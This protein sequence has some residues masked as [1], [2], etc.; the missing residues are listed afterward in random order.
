MRRARALV[1]VALAG[2]ALLLARSRAE[3]P[4]HESPRSVNGNMV[5][6]LCDGETAAEIPGV[7]EGERP[8]RAQAQEV[9]TRLMTDWQRKHPGTT[10]EMAQAVLEPGA[11]QKEAPREVV[12]PRT[13]PASAELPPGAE[14][15][16]QTGQ[17]YGA[18]SERDERVWAAETEKFVREGHRIFHDADALGS[19]NAVSCDMCHPDAANTHPETYPKFQVQL[20]RVALLRDMINWCIQNPTRGRPLPDDD[21]RLKALEAYIIAQRKGATLEFGKH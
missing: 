15:S 18:F 11:E 9:A 3:P 17:T 7:R 20:G 10:W 19:A 21:M 12:P 13:L 6:T 8:T 2:S 14:G 5:V 16:L 4:R 1:V